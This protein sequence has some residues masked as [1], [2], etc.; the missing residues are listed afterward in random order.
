MLGL[1]KVMQQGLQCRAS[2]FRVSS[3]RVCPLSEQLRRVQTSADRNGAL[4]SCAAM[5]CFVSYIN[6]MCVY[7]YTH[8]CIHKCIHACI[9]AYMRAFIDVSVCSHSHTCT[10]VV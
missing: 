3:F 4:L 2:G 8:R 1:F 10:C 7:I 5:P 9:H 6:N